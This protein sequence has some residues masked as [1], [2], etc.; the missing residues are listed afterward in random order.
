MAVV[1]ADS[2]PAS[3]RAALRQ[4]MG[5]LRFAEQRDGVWLRPDN[6]PTG[7]PGESRSVAEAQCAFFSAR[8]AGPSAELA[9]SLW[10]LETWD[11]QARTLVAEMERLGEPLRSGPT[12]AALAEGFVC[13]AAV[14]RHFQA[15]PLLP[16]ELLAGDS[17]GVALRADFDRFY[18]DYQSALAEWFAAR[19]PRPRD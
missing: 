12:R 11:R 10:D 18:L 1:T 13:A 9:A 7:S 16:S 15:D 8:P 3:E 14:L 5:R 6:L 19:D 2:R 17:S 4:A